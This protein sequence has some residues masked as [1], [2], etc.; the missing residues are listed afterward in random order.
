[1]QK[2]NKKTHSLN[3]ESTGLPELMKK[4]E[5]F[6]NSKMSKYFFMYAGKHRLSKTLNQ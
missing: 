1:M 6:E 3:M 4:I 2:S 5:V